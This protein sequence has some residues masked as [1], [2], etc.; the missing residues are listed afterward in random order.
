M[1]NWEFNPI[2]DK[3]DNLKNWV[4]CCEKKFGH[5]GS[6]QVGRMGDMMRHIEKIHKAVDDVIIK[7]LTEDK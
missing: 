5:D 2:G 1:E 3:W 4:E 7:T 6:I